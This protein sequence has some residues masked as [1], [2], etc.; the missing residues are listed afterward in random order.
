MTALVVPIGLNALQRSPVPAPAQASETAIDHY[1]DLLCA[2][3]LG[4]LSHP[5]IDPEGGLRFEWE[6]VDSDGLHWDLRA[7]IEAS[8][9]LYLVALGPT[10]ADDDEMYL[11]H[12]DANLLIRFVNSGII[13]TT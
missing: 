9:G 6:H 1:A 12:F 5:M 10:A 7:V 11:E 4:P 13:P 8:G 3:S 2:L